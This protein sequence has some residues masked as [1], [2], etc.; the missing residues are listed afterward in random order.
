MGE[1]SEVHTAGPWQP[2]LEA[3]SALAVYRTA[4][5]ALTG[6]PLRAPSSCTWQRAG[7]EVIK[8]VCVGSAHSAF[9]VCR[10]PPA[11]GLPQPPSVRGRDGWVCGSAHPDAVLLS[12]VCV[13]EEIQPDPLAPCAW[14]VLPIRGLWVSPGASHCAS[15]LLLPL[16]HLLSLLPFSSSLGRF[17]SYCKRN[18]Y[19]MYK[20]S[21]RPKGNKNHPIVLLPKDNLCARPFSL[22]PAFPFSCKSEIIS[23]CILL[24]SFSKVITL[25]YQYDLFF[26]NI[27]FIGC[28]DCHM[29]EVIKYD[30]RD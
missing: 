18:T 21:M 1:V 12:E 28:L 17:L 10:Q 3:R 26:F 16:S 9:S 4:A 19:S 29:L 7:R 23:L 22:C 8:R 15:C 11:A 14:L 30:S 27:T 25:I 13:A 5:P 6:A 20:I 2:G 24:F